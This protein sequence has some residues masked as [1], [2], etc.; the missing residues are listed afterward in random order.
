MIATI[1][2]KYDT[3]SAVMN[4]RMKRRWAA[5]EALAMR[6]GGLSA[7][8]RATGMSPNTI[9]RGMHEIETELPEWVA[10]LHAREPQRSRRPGGGRWRLAAKDPTL[11]QDL[12]KQLEPVTR[13][14]PMS[15]LL[16]TSKS[17]RHLATELQRQG[18]E[19]SHMTVA[20]LLAQLDY[21]L[22]ANRKTREGAAHADRDAQFHSINRKVQTFHRRGQPVISVDTKKR[23]LVGDFKNAGR[24][25]HP[26]GQ[27]EH[28]RVHDFRDQQLGVAIPYGVYDLGRNDGWVSIGIDHDTAEFAVSTIRRWWRR[29][30]QRAYPR[31]K[32]LLITA[33]AGGSNGSR[34]RL[35]KLGL[36]KL[37]DESGLTISVCH[38]PPGTSKWNKIEH[39]MFCH[40]TENW[41]GRPLVSHAVI[42]NLIGHAKTREGLQVRAA[43]DKGRYEKGVKVSE[44]EFATIN[45]TPES[46]HGDWNYR[47]RPSRK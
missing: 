20:R 8:A 35:W 13:G 40:I 10:S 11:I 28:V 44:K 6:R 46:F 27:P 23:E 33:D 34:S 1:R 22:Q 45:L 14:D 24:E 30:G 5:C 7:V 38:F 41:R 15:H 32:E 25:W 42:V 4:E 9:K 43:L 26:Q 17:T 2:D 36:Q 47:I 18:H 29:M 16:W 39:R 3:L 12:K 31:A 19:V 21:H 37:V